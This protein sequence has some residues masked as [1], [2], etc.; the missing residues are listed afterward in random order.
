MANQIDIDGLQG[1]KK[2]AILLIALGRDYTSKVLSYLDD[3]DLQDVSKEIATTNYVEPNV[4]NEVVKEFYN[5]Y[6]AR[7][8]I[9]QGGI[10]YARDA[11]T[12]ALGPEKAEKLIGRL[13]KFLEQGRG[14]EFLSKVDP[15]QLVKI[16]Q[17]EHPQTIALILAHMD[18]SQAAE[19]LSSLPDELKA[20]VSF[21]IANLQDISPSVVK[22]LSNVLEDKFETLSSYD[23]EVGGLRNVA[24][25]LNRMD[26]QTS[27]KILERM[28]KDDPE[29][30][31][32]IRDMMFVF[33]DIKK[34]DN[35][36]IQEILKRVDRKVLTIALKGADEE[37]SQRIFRNMSSRAVQILKEEMEYMGP[38][39]LR[40]VEEAQQEVVQIV[41]QLDSEDVISIHGGEDQY[42]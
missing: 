1:T 8:Y 2:A 18:S 25:I 42:I 16:I 35:S 26:K 23:V 15:K 27:G 36:A 31:A 41:R 30:A 12:K 9:L 34:L 37:L 28:D 39:R 24:E 14:F 13:I 17:N 33:D 7:K 22:T 5:M 32:K 29:L 40:D 4:A 21:R 10:D 6:L 38:V 3:A 11:L 19:A 20:E